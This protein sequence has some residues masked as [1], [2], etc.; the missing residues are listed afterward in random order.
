MKRFLLKVFRFI[1][2][3]ATGF[4]LHASKFEID[5]KRLGDLSFIMYVNINKQPNNLLPTQ[6]VSIIHVQI[7]ACLLF[8]VPR[9]LLPDVMY[10]T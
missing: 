1:T 9:K 10:H 4:A 3:L 5:E 7:I 2:G 8:D 6:G